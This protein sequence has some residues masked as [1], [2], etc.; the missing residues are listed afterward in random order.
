MC[1]VMSEDEYHNDT[2]K[3]NININ[4]DV[5]KIEMIINK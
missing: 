1:A 3:I 5:V 4:I 2:V